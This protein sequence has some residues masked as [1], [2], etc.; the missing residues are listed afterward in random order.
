MAVKDSYSRARA[1]KKTSS[2]KVTNNLSKREQKKVVKSFKN[3]PILII[4][5]LFLIVGAIGGFFAFKML[6]PFEMN[7]FTIN[8]VASAEN[9]Y[10]IVDVSS[11]KEEY[12]KTNSEATMSEI[13]ASI[14]LKD[15]LVECKF[16]GKDI[17]DTVSIKYYYREDI[18]H[19]TVET[20]NV[21]VET[22]GV[23][24]IEYT[25]FHFAFKNK[26]L[27]RTIIITG[28]ENDG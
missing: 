5:V 9:D 12:L 1:T 21:D 24:Y 17:S 23:Y 6:S 11:I 16:F 3:S 26:T 8:G 20:T 27:I 7:T 18:S 15:N 28:V 22:A 4:A 19:N 2:V 25:S 14:L 10:V 13:Y